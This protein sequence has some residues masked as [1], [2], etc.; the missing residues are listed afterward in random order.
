[1][2][3]SRSSQNNQGQYIVEHDGETPRVTPQVFYGGAASSQ[4][5]PRSPR[6]D[7]IHN[8]CKAQLEEVKGTYENELVQK[9]QQIQN[10]HTVLNEKTGEA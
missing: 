3:R 4:L 5:P 1:M 10:L 2:A 7:Q 8:K 9:M 6:Q